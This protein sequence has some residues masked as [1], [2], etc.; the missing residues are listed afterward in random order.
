MAVWT[1]NRVENPVYNSATGTAAAAVTA[2]LPAGSG[3][4]T[5]IGGF[6]VTSGAPTA[7]VSG[8]VTVTGLAPWLGSNGTLSF[9]FVESATVGGELNIDFPFLLPASALNAAITVT[10]PAI[11]SGAV[12]SVAAYGIVS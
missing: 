11:T 5:F 8:T 2:A 3:L 1:A 6:T 10:C 4:T 9:Q 12:V 7:T